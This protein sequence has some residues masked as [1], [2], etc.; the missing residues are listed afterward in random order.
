MSGLFKKKSKA[1]KLQEQHQ[2]LMNEAYEL[3]KTNRAESD[4]K[5]AEAEEVMTQLEALKRGESR[6]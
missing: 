1:E 6:D 2:K 3:S 5:Y 4:K